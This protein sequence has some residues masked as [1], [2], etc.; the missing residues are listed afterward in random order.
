MIDYSTDEFIKSGLSIILETKDPKKMP[1]PSMELLDLQWT[2]Q[3]LT[4]MS[5]AAE[6]TAY[7]YDNV[8]EDGSVELPARSVYGSEDDWHSD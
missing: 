5:A 8:D 6:P 1:L 2:L 7:P 4:A 3:R